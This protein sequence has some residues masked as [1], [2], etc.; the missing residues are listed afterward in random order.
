MANFYQ[1]LRDGGFLSEEQL[2]S[3]LA[4][5]AQQRNSTF[6]SAL[7][8]KGVFPEEQLL[9]LAS[10]FFNVKRISNPYSVEVDFVATEKVVRSI[11]DAIERKMFA[12]HLDGKMTF[13]LNDPENEIIRSKAT[14]ALGEEPQFAIVSES[15]F[16]VFNQYQLTP[17]AVKE[18]AVQLKSN[19]GG[20]DSSRDDTGQKASNTQKLLD[21]MISAALDRRASDLHIQR[22]DDSTARIMLRID[23]VMYPFTDISADVLPNLRNKLKTMSEV[24]GETPAKPVEGQI[25]V[26]H[27]G[28]DVDIRIDIVY[29]ANGYDFCMRFIDS[30]LKSLEEFG[31]SDENYNTFLRLIHMTKGLIILCGPTGSGKTTLLYAG[32]KKLLAENKMIFTIEDPVEISLPG[33]TQMEVKAEQGFTYEK[34]FPSSL[35]HDP[36]VI[37]I[38]ETRTKDVGMQA[39]QAANTGHLVFTTLHTN[40]SVGAIA[41]LSNMGIEPYTIGDSLAAVVAQRLIRRICTNCAEEYELPKD[42]V[43]RTV[44]NLGDGPIKLKRGCG[45]AECGG[46]GYRGR[47]AVS[48]FLVTNPRIRNAIQKG[49][50]RTEI[51]EILDKGGFKT[52]LEDAI[53]KARAG[54]TTFS[55]VDVLNNDN[56]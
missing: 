48:E 42:H 7:K 44:Y 5:Q 1:W 26:R 25:R 37:G 31:L 45:C 55:E 20:D 18:Q 16:N 53:D 34:Q 8:R 54:I 47:I 39:I 50:T 24:G 6:F 10:T 41:R 22:M 9:Q 40:D 28:M 43:W 36:D 12:V 13:V 35:R 30:N 38:G 11:F 17:R 49:A 15:D 27:R 23:G 2:K 33:V 4:E 21:M 46:T 3:V 29:T 32:F 51:N 52:Y 14:T 19:V 56:V